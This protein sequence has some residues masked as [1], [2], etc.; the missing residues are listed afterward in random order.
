MFAIIGGVGQATRAEKY[1][2]TFIEQR[3]ALHKNL[4]KD[5]VRRRQEA[6]SLWGTREERVNNFLKQRAPVGY[7]DSMDFD[8]GDRRML[9][10]PEMCS[11][12]NIKRQPLDVSKHFN[13]IKDG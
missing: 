13:N 1:S 8:H 4:S 9:P 5:L 11:S 12:E 10:P 7:D 2:L 3:D 6:T